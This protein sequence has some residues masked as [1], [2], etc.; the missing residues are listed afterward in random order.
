MLCNNRNFFS[1]VA[2]AVLLVCMQLQEGYSFVN[3]PLRNARCNAASDHKY[4]PPTTW[5]PGTAN[6][7]Q[8]IQPLFGSNSEGPNSSVD[9]TGRGSVIQVLVLLG[10][11]WLFSIPP[12]F[13]RAHFCVGER[14]GIPCVENRAKCYDCVTFKEWTSDVSEYYKNGGGVQFDFTVGEETKDLF[15]K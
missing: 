7:R 10:I 8:I 13:R 9:G 14:G 2:I 15:S 4:L 11:V 12:E 1:K 3:H 5:Q 6:N